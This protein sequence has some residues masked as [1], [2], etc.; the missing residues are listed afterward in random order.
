MGVGGDPRRRPCWCP[1]RPWAAPARRFP[2]SREAV[3][4]GRTG[5]LLFLSDF[6]G[7]NTASFQERL[8]WGR[9]GAHRVVFLYIFS[10]ILPTTPSSTQECEAQ[11]G[12]PL[13]PSPRPVS[14]QSLPLAHLPSALSRGAPSDPSIQCPEVWV[15]GIASA[16][17]SPRTLALHGQ[18]P[19]GLPH[20][21][22][23]SIPGGHSRLPF[24]Q[25]LVLLLRSPWTLAHTSRSVY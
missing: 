14:P 20:P 11:Q 10:Q 9:R 24:F 21:A 22:Q 4:A 8:T 5:N 25:R 7:S 1:R 2:S 17:H 19:S 13:G 6:S 18:P 3:S 23:V 15:L 12:S 16:V